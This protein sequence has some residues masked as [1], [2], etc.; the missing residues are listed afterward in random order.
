MR[1]AVEDRIDKET[2]EIGGTNQ[3]RL[4]EGEL[5]GINAYKVKGFEPRLNDPLKRGRRVTFRVEAQVVEI[6]AH[7]DKDGNLI[8]THILEVKEACPEGFPA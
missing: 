3:L 2:G 6:R 1:T 8:R 4:F 5:V 7:K